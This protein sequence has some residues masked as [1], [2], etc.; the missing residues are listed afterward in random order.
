[1][2]DYYQ[3][4]TQ[5]PKSREYKGPRAKLGDLLPY[6]KDHRKT[7][8]LALILSV[9]GSLLALGQP[10][11]IGQLITAVEQSLDTS[12]LAIFIVVLVIT[13]AL[14]NAFQYYLLFKTGEGVVLTTRKALVARL[15]R[16]PI[17]QYDR[18]R[19][20]DL[21]SRVGSDS[22]LLKAVLTQ[23][24]V[25]A[26]GGLLQFF[27]AIIVMAFID[28]IL[29]ATTLSVV[30]VAVGAIA[31]TGRRIRSATTKAQM[32]VGEMSASV[33]R[34]LSAIRTIKAARAEDRETAEIDKDAHA[35]YD[36]GLSIARLSAIVSP[37]AQVA[38]NSAFII[39]LG[40]G[41]LRVA[42]GTTSIASLVTF[43]ILLFFMIGPL[44]S[45]FGAYTSVMG[46]LGALARIKEIMD[47]EEEEPGGEKLPR[48]RQ[49]STAIEFKNVRFSYAVDDDEEP[50]EI[51]KGIDLKIA[52]G[53]RVA[54]VGPSGSGKSTVFSLIERFY[55]PT[56]GE[57]L[58][59]GQ[60]VTEFSRDSLRQ[61]LG[62]VEQDA[63][64][65]AGSLKDNL[66]LGRADATDEELE[67]VLSQVN[68]SDVLNR[69][70]KGLGAEVGEDGIMLSGGERQRLAIARALL[71]SPEILLLDESTSAL[72]G[73][74]EQRMREA[75]DAVA[76]DR[77]LMV[78]AHRLS[79]VVDSD[80]IIVL[81]HGEIVGVG[82]HSEL[83]KSTPLYKDLA[84]HQLLV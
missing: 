28:P 29:L 12:T 20:G 59:D 50:K 15:L 41:G 45:A 56:S 26:L 32:R 27:G 79:T 65:L 69:D 62:Y 66:L 81:E 47:L 82:T 54:L 10:L 64:V 5:N 71:A 53:S 21:V 83:I 60:P 31:L 19:I 13:S 22:T 46:A 37:I 61:Q 11:L 51:I 77:T 17:W 43:V 25:D 38:F 30:F 48:K 63:P 1:M 70:S 68:L 34:A 3:D 39:V 78:I 2:S 4:P 7:L 80:Q 8:I 72:D 52:R 33:E 58:L 9:L 16:L 44:I 73:P 75:I 49:N 35:A 57:I 67:K 36:Q 23:G 6:L 18:R 74:N 40:L 14:V 55:E 42:T 84:K 76:H 24:L